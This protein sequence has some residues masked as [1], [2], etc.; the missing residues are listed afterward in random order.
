MLFCCLQAF[1]ADR[2][3]DEE[4]GSISRFQ[5]DPDSLCQ[6]I[7]SFGAIVNVCH[8]YT[9]WHSGHL[10]VSPRI[11]ASVSP[12]QPPPSNAAA[13]NQ[14]KV[15]S[16]PPVTTTTSTSAVGRGPPNADDKKESQ[17]RVRDA[18]IK[19]G[20][21]LDPPHADSATKRQPSSKSSRR[22][23]QKKQE[24]KQNQ[25]DD[26]HLSKPQEHTS[27]DSTGSQLQSHPQPRPQP[28]PQ[29]GTSLPSVKAPKTDNSSQNRKKQSSSSGQRHFEESVVI[30]HDKNRSKQQK[31]RYRNQSTKVPVD[32]EGDQISNG[33][34]KVNSKHSKWRRRQGGAKSQ[35]P[36]PDQTKPVSTEPTISEEGTTVVVANGLPEDPPK[37]VGE[38]EPR[39]GDLESTE[40]TGN[41]PTVGRRVDDI[42]EGETPNN[43]DVLDTLPPSLPASVNVNNNS[44]KPPAKSNGPL[45]ESQQKIMTFEDG[46]NEEGKVAKVVRKQSIRITPKPAVPPEE[47]SFTL[48][49]E[50]ST[51]D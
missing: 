28:H 43:G 33:N 17:A 24:S 2:K 38:S 49:A 48:K 15:K 19:Q 35:S 32:A 6:Q 46:V 13:V 36:P 42:T 41:G 10:T 25:G 9:S 31:Y 7:S 4:I 18:V 3:V 39:P 45:E 22:R 44:N 5:C 37:E 50:E 21:V 8:T 14:T 47:L 23:N 11:L 51:E 30:V 12:S 16:R 26:R 20:V 29:S 27:N 1:I 34:K 40:D